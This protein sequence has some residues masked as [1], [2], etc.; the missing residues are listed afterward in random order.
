MS[1]VGTYKLRSVPPAL[2]VLLLTRSHKHLCFPAQLHQIWQCTGQHSTG[3][4][5]R[6]SNPGGGE[7]FRARPDRPWG[8]PNVIYS[9]YC[10]FIGGK[11]AGTWRWPSTP[12]SAE[13]KERVELYLYFPSGLSWPVLW[14]ILPLPSSLHILVDAVNKYININKIFTYKNIAYIN[15]NGLYQYRY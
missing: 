1:S 2:T 4:T 14:W 12:S 10:V 8:P 9:E 7:I 3:W 11:A 5:V 15:S 13:V 6:G